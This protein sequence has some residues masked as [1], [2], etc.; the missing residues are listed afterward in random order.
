MNLRNVMAPPFLWPRHLQTL[1]LQLQHHLPNLSNQYHLRQY[2]LFYP[3]PQ[4]FPS[5]LSFRQLSLTYQHRQIR[6]RIQMAASR[7]TMMIMVVMVIMATAM[8][9]TVLMVRASPGYR[10]RCAAS[11]TI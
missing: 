8:G 7:V 4:S 6:A 3:H 9:L 5:F 10:R 2:H 1:L 11:S